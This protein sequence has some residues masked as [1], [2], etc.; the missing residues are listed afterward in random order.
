MPQMTTDVHMYS[1]YHDVP[2][3][4]EQ[5]K[6]AVADTGFFRRMHY[7]TASPWRAKHKGVK[8]VEEINGFKL[9]I[10]YHDGN[11]FVGI[12]EAESTAQTREQSEFLANYIRETVL[13]KF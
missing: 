11:S 9:K 13:K 5:L 10:H 1:S 6:Q 4:F 8:I 3:E 2:Q 12:I 7:S